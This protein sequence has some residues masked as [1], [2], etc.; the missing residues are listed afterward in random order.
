VPDLNPLID[1]PSVNLT[2][3]DHD[4][5]AVPS[6]D[7]KLAA[8]M[9]H[10]QQQ[11]GPASQSELLAMSKNSQ[12]DWGTRVGAGTVAFA[13]HIGESLDSMV[14][15]PSRAWNGQMSDQ[16]A[17]QWG[18]AVATTMLGTGVPLAEPGLGILGGKGAVGADIGALNL[19]KI[20]TAA[21][22]TADS[23]WANTGWGEFPDREWKFEIS[24]QAS[25]LEPF[26][27]GRKIGN[28]DEVFK[29]SELFARYPDLKKT[30]VE[31]DHH[32]AADEYGYFDKDK[33]K[34]VINPT[35][36]PPEMK[37]TLLH[38]IQHWVQDREGFA[39]GGSPESPVIQKKLPEELL[40]READIAGRLR[41]FNQT[42]QE[43]IATK[44][45]ENPSYGLV[46]LM[47]ENP[48]IE[49]ALNDLFDEHQGI[50]AEKSKKSFVSST[51]R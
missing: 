29:H 15:G 13:K 28:L 4:P 30:E 49:S 38:E 14:G 6:Q 7:E 26:T 34:I 33:N 41:Q 17:S 27:D 48:H 50:L 51:C 5:W 23:T 20:R 39:Y 11:Q 18:P 10:Q 47:T 2:P 3:V 12:L 32:L 16:E 19:A 42:A 31:F 35:L 44:K 40:A 46:D 1:P 22:Q 24:D 21:G 45:Q 9:S 8:E 43:F 37:A 25:K 36:D